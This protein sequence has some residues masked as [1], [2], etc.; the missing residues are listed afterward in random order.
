MENLIHGVHV[1]AA[2]SEM[3]AQAKQQFEELTVDRSPEYDQLPSNPSFTKPRIAAEMV[4]QS[5]RHL[6]ELAVPLLSGTRP[7]LAE[8]LASLIAGMFDFTHEVEAAEAGAK[9]AP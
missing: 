6:G 3:A 1:A 5:A 9:V 2:R 4:R 8:R 7:A